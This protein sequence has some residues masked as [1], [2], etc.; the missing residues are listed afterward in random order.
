MYAIV[1]IS[2]FDYKVK[3]GDRI[4][5][6]HQDAKEGSKLKF[7][8]VK[9]LKDDELKI[10]PDATVIT[11]VL[12]HRKGR[13]IIVYKF[14]K[15]KGY[16]RKT[17]YRDMLTDLKVTAIKPGT[18]NKGK[19]PAKGGESVKATETSKP[20]RPKAKSGKEKSAKGNEE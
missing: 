6:P 12:S 4:S 1:E 9:L 8:S 17:G 11:E 19:T 2:G 18:S 16:R 14:K 3:P 15:R 7:T 13:K 5:V 10:N 20:A